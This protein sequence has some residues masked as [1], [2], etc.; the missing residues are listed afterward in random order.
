MTTTGIGLIFALKRMFPQHRQWMACS[1]AVA[2]VFLEVRFVLGLTGLDQPF[3]WPIAEA[4]VWSCLVLAIPLADLAN[5]WHELATARPR[6]LGA[7]AKASVIARP[8]E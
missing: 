3:S 1:V 5:Q 6:P 4:A 2:L 7:D 8:A